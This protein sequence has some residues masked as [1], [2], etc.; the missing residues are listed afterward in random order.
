MIFVSFGNSLESFGVVVN[1]KCLFFIFVFFK[2][3]PNLF[4]LLS[5]QMFCIFY[6]FISKESTKVNLK[7]VTQ[8]KSKTQIQEVC[9]VSSIV[10]LLLKGIETFFNYVK[11]NSF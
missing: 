2:C 7:K 8:S 11:N 1:F 9:T 6:Y 10:L 5:D 4:W 3:Q